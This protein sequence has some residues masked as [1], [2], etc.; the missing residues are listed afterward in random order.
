MAAKKII[1]QGS[2]GPLYDLS[3]WFLGDVT[4]DYAAT[5]TFFWPMEVEDNCFLALRGQ[6]GEMAWLHATW[7]EWKNTFP[8]K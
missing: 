7:T 4:L 2:L 1:E 6:R 8:S 3:R 5:P